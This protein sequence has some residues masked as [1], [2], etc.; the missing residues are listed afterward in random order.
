MFK[1]SVFRLS[2]CA[3]SVALGQTATTPPA[4]APEDP[5]FAPIVLEPKVV[6]LNRVSIAFQSGFNLK[7]SFKNIGRFGAAANPGSTNGLSNHF[8]DDGYNLVDSANNQHFNGTGFTQGTWNWGFNNFASQV[9]GNGD[10][11]GTIDMH[12]TSSAGGTSSGHDD[13]VQ[14]GFML[15]FSRELFRNEKDTWRTGLEWSFGYT[16]YSA[17]DS[18]PVN[19]KATQL[20][21]SYST[22]GNTLPN[23]ASYSQNLGGDPNHIIIGDTMARSFSSTTVPVSGTRKFDANL[24]AFKMGPYFEVPLNKTFSFSLEGGAELVYVYSRFQFNEEVV[25]PSGLLNVKGNNTDDGVQLGG[26]LGAKVSAAL[27][28]KWSLFAGAEWQD[29]GSYIHHNHATGES[30]VLDLSQAAFFTFGVG[31]SF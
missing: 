14:P 26:Y 22:F 28:D 2:V 23:S 20:T 31:Y 17:D 9:H 13:N 15:T 8:Y 5:P 18:S 21:D 4:A 7:T 12:S 19:A 30:A 1:N 11:D 6:S 25:T 29:V 27:N 10:L 3:T 24:F 16:D